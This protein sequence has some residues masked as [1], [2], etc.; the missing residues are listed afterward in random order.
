MGLDVVERAEGEGVMWLRLNRPT[1]LNALDRA[2]HRALTA[3]FEELTARP[4]LSVV[5]LA[6]NGRSFSAGADI[7]NDPPGS[8]QSLP[9]SARRHDAGTWQRLLELLDRVPQVT[10]ASLHGHCYGGAALL[11]VSCDLRLADT[12]LRV[13]I[14]ELQ[15]GIPLTWSGIPR[16]VREIGLPAARD[17]VMSTRIIDADEALRLG[18]VQRLVDSELPAAT[19]ALVDELKNT[20][21]ATLA[22]TRAMFA[23]ISREATSATGWADPD[24]L[25]WSLAEP[26]A[27]PADRVVDRS[28]E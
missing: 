9:W 11:A 14:P 15:M 6:G 7:T 17:L 12:S 20:P 5:V 10:V 26:D 23:A 21:P 16:L 2:T 13:R 4:D 24:L 27:H 18:F 28:G 25:S 8:N 19:E 22:L 1:K 3:A